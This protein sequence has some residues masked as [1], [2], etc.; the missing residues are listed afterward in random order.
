MKYPRIDLKEIEEL[1]KK[2]FEERLKFIEFYVE[3]LKKTDNKTWSKQ[4]AKI[5]NK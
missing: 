3:W 2:N 1:K 4:Q 5:I